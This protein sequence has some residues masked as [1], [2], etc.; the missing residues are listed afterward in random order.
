MSADNCIAICKFRQGWKVAHC[1]GIENLWSWMLKDK[2]SGEVFVIKKLNLR[3]LYKYFADSKVYKIKS[4]ALKAAMDM[5]NKI[6]F[7]EYGI[8][9]IGR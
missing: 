5:Y 3:M 6:G 7:V 9:E 1:Q 8:I 4:R 2:N